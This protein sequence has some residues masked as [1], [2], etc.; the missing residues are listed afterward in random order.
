MARRTTNLSMMTWNVRRKV[1]IVA[2]M[3]GM[4]WNTCQEYVEY[5]GVHLNYFYVTQRKIQDQF[6]YL[7][8]FPMKTNLTIV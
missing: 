2:F 3:V 7:K 1:K 8:K 5:I 6:P 4:I